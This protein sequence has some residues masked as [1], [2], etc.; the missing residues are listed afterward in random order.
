M[1]GK[2]RT[3]EE[4]ELVGPKMFKALISVRK[5]G[6]YPSKNQLAISVGPNGSQKYGYDIVD[7]CRYKDL[8]RVDPDHADATPNGLGSVVL[9]EKGERFLE[10]QEDSQ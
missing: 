1:R 4:N 5:N 3:T 8:L 6:Y 9:T 2:F 10:N 7:R